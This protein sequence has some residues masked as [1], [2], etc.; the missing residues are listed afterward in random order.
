MIPMHAHESHPAIVRRLR[1][2]GGHLQSVIEMIE[3]GRPCLDIAQQLQAV[4]KAV[5]QAKK[6]LVQDHL[7]HCLEHMIEVSGP[8]RDRELDAFKLITKY[9]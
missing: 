3:Q 7:D 9:L 8:Q 4:E 1:R 5:A 2:A 6:T